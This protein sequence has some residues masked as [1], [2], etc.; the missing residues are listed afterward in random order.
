MRARVFV[1]V[2]MAVILL[3]V[4]A[5]ALTT[6]TWVPFGPGR[7]SAASVCSEY[8]FIGARGSGQAPQGA[9]TD[10]SSDDF[11]GLGEKGTG[12]GEIAALYLSL[13]KLLSAKAIS[14]SVYGVHYPA[15]NVVSANGLEAALGF[16]GGYTNSVK[17]GT[18][19]AV[20]QINKIHATCPETKFILAGY[21][22]GAQVIGDAIQKGG[23][24]PSLIAGA[25]L[26]GDPYFNPTDS[27]VDRSTYDPDLYGALGTRPVFSSS[28]QGKVFSYCHDLDIVCNEWKSYHILGDGNLFVRDVHVSTTTHLTPAYCVNSLPTTDTY[29]PADQGDTDWAARTIASLVGAPPTPTSYDGPLDLAFAVDSTGSMGGVIGQVQ[30]N[31]TTLVQ[32]ISTIDSD[33]R[34][35]LV[36]YKDDP[37]DDSA[38]QSRVDTDFTTDISTFTSA[39]DSLTA[40]G[41]GDTPESVYSGIMTA[42]SLDWR[43][44]VKK[45]VIQIGDAAAKDPE[46]VTGYTLNDVRQKALAVDPATV[47]TVQAGSDPDATASFQSIAAATGGSYLDLPDE[48]DLS[49]LIPTIIQAITNSAS[50]P[51]A[52]LTVAADGGTVGTPVDFSAAGS[53][54]SSEPITDY[55]WD[56]NDDGVYD[57]TTT[58][59]YASFTYSAPYSGNVVVRVRA[60]SGLSALASEPLSVVSAPTSKPAAPTALTGTTGDG[61]VSL[62]WSS[63]ASGPTPEWYTIYDSKGNEIDRVGAA[64]DGTASVPWI[65]DGLTDGTP[66]TFEVSAGNIVGESAR[67]GPITL[68]PSAPKPPISIVISGGL[69]YSNSGTANSGGFT[70]SYSNVRLVSVTGKAAIPGVKGGSADV[71]LQVAVFSGFDA[72][73]IHVGDESAGID[74]SGVILSRPLQE[75]GGEISGTAYG[76]TFSGRHPAPFEINWSVPVSDVQIVAHH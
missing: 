8:E 75:S 49:N 51:N 41:G 32:N 65:E 15:V 5:L 63:P 39:L 67:V 40:E 4:S 13:Q 38:Y 22:Q 16:G 10:Y 45:V 62:S 7:A 71:T 50:A 46:P 48:S 43:T 60:A 47:D 3:G 66:Y 30:S 42:L 6:S 34:V 1:S 27:G 37:A 23:I 31:V 56:F 52:A 54:D 20:A 9:S 2:S 73:Y 35:A 70:A 72:G 28:L 18:S 26:F 57:L 59:P 14:L 11:Y 69:T 21:S 61:Q 29:C 74:T 58:T 76:L 24:S 12:P 53:T 19:D 44:G 68:T 36:D 17:Q 55:D 25:A 33:V 64:A